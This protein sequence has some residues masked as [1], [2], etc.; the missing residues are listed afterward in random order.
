V[1]DEATT[2]ILYIKPYVMIPGLISRC[3]SFSVQDD[4][5]VSDALDDTTVRLKGLIWEVKGS[6]NKCVER[7]QELRS[8]NKYSLFA[9]STPTD[10]LSRT[11]PSFLYIS[12]SSNSIA[13][14]SL[15]PYTG[16]ASRSG[17]IELEVVVY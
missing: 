17:C 10:W 11:H 3:G 2:L 1:V 14:Y 15:S 8:N 4:D 6:P 5:A 13:G 12:S 9:L 16:K 7:R